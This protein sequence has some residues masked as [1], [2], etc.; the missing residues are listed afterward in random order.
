MSEEKARTAELVKQSLSATT[1]EEFEQRL[2]AQAAWLRDAIET[3]TLDNE[4]FT[5]GLEMELYAVTDSDQAAGEAAATTP[6]L[7]RLPTSVFEKSGVNK[8]LGLHNIEINTEPTVLDDAGLRDQ[9]EAI[10][11]RTEAAK[12]AANAADCEVVLDALWTLPPT[13]GAIEYLSATEEHD[14]IF[15][16]ENMRQA[17]RYVGIDNHALEYAGGAVPFS[18]TGVKCSFPSILFE[19]LATSIQPHFQVPTATEFP[20]YYNTAIRTLGPILAL[21]TNSPFLPPGFY[22]ED[23]DPQ[24]VVDESP[25]ELRIEVFEQSVN[26]T[27]N[28]KVRVPGDID[29]TAEVVDRVVADDSYSPFLREW[30]TDADR[31]TL[32]DRLW[33]FNHKRGTYWRWLRCVIGGD[34]IDDDNDERSLRIEYRP[35]PTQPSVNDVIGMQAL[36]VGLLRGLVVADHPL[37][38]L[39]WEAAEESFYNAVNDGLAADLSWITESGDRTTDSETIGEEI[40]R[41]ARQGLES[42][43]VSSETIDSL[44]APIEARWDAKMTPSDW[45]KQQV[46][47]QL[48]A[49]KSLETA[50]AEMQATYIERSQTTDS[51]AAWL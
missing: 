42:E 13:D 46:R 25:H 28:D 41:Y 24:Q 22:T 49:G 44:L 15:F 29:T 6:Q 35:I 9:A 50:I 47:R 11:D 31:E 45:K 20:T 37:R 36:T 5:V 40:F 39:P 8:E 1:A 2:E 34:Y 4:D 10:R 30:L 27:P 23:S 14:E 3:G 16:A 38:E 12:A 51:F 26:Q 33:E 48:A 19:S 7:A 43:G 21:S 32:S 17:P 18:V